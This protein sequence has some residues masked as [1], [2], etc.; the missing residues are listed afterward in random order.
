MFVRVYRLPCRPL[1]PVLW[2]G[3]RLDEWQPFADR[4]WAGIHYWTDDL[5]KWRNRTV[6]A[7][8]WFGIINKLQIWLTFWFDLVSL[9]ADWVLPGPMCSACVSL[10]AACSLYTLSIIL[11]LL[12][13]CFTLKAQVSLKKN[14]FFTITKITKK[15]KY[16]QPTDDWMEGGGLTINWLW[17]G[18]LH[19]Y[20]IFTIISVVCAYTELHCLNSK[21]FA[22]NIIDQCT[23]IHVVDKYSLLVK[24]NKLNWH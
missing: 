24:E 22:R 17:E 12:F 14:L 18:V 1:S 4:I 5:V 2:V 20:F 7:W 3:T 6:I 21:P 19:F 9:H 8:N 11:F 23:F 13:A 16:Q 10:N 15:K